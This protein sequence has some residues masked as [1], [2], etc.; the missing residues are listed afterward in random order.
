RGDLSSG[1]R[2][3]GGGAGS[4]GKTSRLRDVLIVS[5]LAFAVILMVGAGLLLRT[6]RH[7]LREG[8]GFNSARLVTANIQLP[9]HNDPNAD[10]YFAIPR[11]AG[12]ARELVRRMKAIP[13]MELAAVTSALPTTNSN[14]NSAGGLAVEGFAIEDRPVESSLDLRAERIRISPDY[15]RVLQATLLRGRSFTD[16]D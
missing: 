16:G 11:R 3:G 5:E 7:L 14:P 15:F 12:F 6:L 2:E 10:P 1:I 4:S 13:G 9:N 8:P